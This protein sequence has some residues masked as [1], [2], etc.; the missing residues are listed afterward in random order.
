MWRASSVLQYIRSCVH[1][2]FC[3]SFNQN[4]VHFLP[5]FTP[6]TLP[7]TMKVAFQIVQL[8]LLNAVALAA[9]TSADNSELAQRAILNTAPPV[10]AGK[11]AGVSQ[12]SGLTVVGL[13][14]PIINTQGVTTHW[15]YVMSDGSIR[16]V[17][18]V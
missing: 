8:L 14:T 17:A 18:V 10:N 16:V 15:R 6:R 12:G 11:S 4:K 5:V 13:P 2:L 7:P 9:P 3:T 1:I